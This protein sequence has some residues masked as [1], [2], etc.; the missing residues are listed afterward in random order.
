MTNDLTFFTNDPSSTL[1]ER[2]K[3][4]LRFTQHFDVLVGYFRASGFYL[5]QDA[6]EGVE[7]IRI[8]VG[9]NVDTRVYSI[10]EKF[11]G[12][13]ALDFE[14]HT[15]MQEVYAGNLAFEMEHSEDRAEVEG[16]IRKL[17]EFML[18]GKL[19]IKAHP[20][21]NIHAKVY[22]CRHHPEQSSDFG[23]VITGSSNFSQSGLQ[24]QYEFNVELKT[25]ADVNYALEHFERLWAEAV[26]LNETFVE[27]LQQNTWLNDTLTPYE[28][29][30][31]FLYEYFKEDMNIDQEYD[32]YLP[33]GFKEL[34]Y[35]KQA[36]IS[37]KKILDAYGGVFLADVVGLGKTFI[38][39]LL[40]QQLPGRKLVICPPVLVD[41]WKE[42]FFQFGIVAHVESLGKLDH[43][44]PSSLDR[45]DYVFV[46]E[47]HRFRNELTKSYEM[48][49]RICRRKKVILV[50]ATPLN[51]TIRDIYSQIKLFQ[52]PRQS[53]I[54]GLPNLEKFFDEHIHSLEKIKREDPDAYVQAVRDVA[55]K[56]RERVLKYVMVRRTRSEIVN[57]FSTDMNAQGIAFPTINDPHKIPYLFDAVTDQVFC[58]TIEKL[59]KFTYSR[60]MPLLYSICPLSPL[61]EQSQRNIGGFMKSVLVKRLESSFY[62]FQRTLGRFIQS[63]HHFIQMYHNGK[64]YI[65]DNVNVQDYLETD[66]IGRAS[67]RER[68]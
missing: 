52:N 41:Y 54:P 6:L 68:V 48:L 7:H 42:T 67:C 3:S 56:V 30:I 58:Q 33:Q 61:E 24:D 11:R 63:Y 36:V 40:A 35:Q 22:I 60:Y 1:L 32:V 55:Q 49:Y 66:K 39:A 25:R 37:A 43:I 17:L 29:Y 46:D 16:G 4:V 34:A 10:V 47:A 62:A 23:K 65:S 21:Q 28:L 57:Y 5:M 20:S 13:G 64:I 14:S 9:L 18:S 27:T 44:L 53:L 45:F 8:L 12:Q 31:K 38:A 26:D 59:S 50:S 19:E 2:F 15:R 51:N